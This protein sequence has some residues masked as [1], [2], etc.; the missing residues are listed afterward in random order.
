MKHTKANV[1]KVLRAVQENDRKIAVHWLQAGDRKRAERTKGEIMAI[2]EAIMLL[3]RKTMF[4]E[5]VK[6]YEVENATD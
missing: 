3:T 2:D 4:D 6:I 5:Y 1:I